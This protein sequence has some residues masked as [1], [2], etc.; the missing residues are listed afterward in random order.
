MEKK[1]WSSTHSEG[2]AAVGT[3]I[4][5][6]LQAWPALRDLRAKQFITV[7]TAVFYLLIGIVVWTFAWWIKEVRASRQPSQAIDADIKVGAVAAT[8][9]A[10]PSMPWR[11]ENREAQLSPAEKRM[12]TKGQ[13]NLLGL[14]FGQKICLALV[15]N[16]PGI[17]IGAVN[18]QLYE[19]G[20]REANRDSSLLIETSL[21]TVVGRDQLSPSPERIVRGEVEEYLRSVTLAN[22]FHPHQS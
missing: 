2:I 10:G 4:A 19:L 15:Y 9:D 6:L 18:Q 11:T 13:V 12:L 5:L 3:V 22:V 20:F 8:A 7:G 1:P 17:Q 21:I 16:Q 14:N